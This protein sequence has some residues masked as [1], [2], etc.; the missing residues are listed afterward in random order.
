MVGIPQPAVITTRQTIDLLALADPTR[1]AVFGT[2]RRVADGVLSDNAGAWEPNQG[3]ARLAL[4]Y[5]PPEEYDYRIVFTKQSGQHCVSPIFVANG[6]AF[7]W[8]MGGWNNTVFAFENVRG[9]HGGELANTTRIV[10]PSCL[11]TGHRHETVLRVRRTGTTAVFDGV[12]ITSTPANHDGMTSPPVYHLHN[13]PGQLGLAS[14][15]SPTLFHTV[16]VVEIS[17]SGTFTRP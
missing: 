13:R 10:R 12:E 1:D 3:A 4:P 7:A 8:I 16:E 17:G 6:Q 15:Q 14:W 5:R 11:I 2:W 9:L